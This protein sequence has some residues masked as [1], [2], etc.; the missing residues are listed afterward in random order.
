MI[1]WVDFLLL[2]IFVWGLYR[3]GLRRARRYGAVYKG[4]DQDFA[5][6]CALSIEESPLL[7]L[8]P[9]PEGAEAHSLVFDTESVQY[10]PTSNFRPLFEAVSSPLLV[11]LSWILLDAEGRAI[12]HE[13]HILRTGELISMEA[14]DYHGLTNDYVAGH[15]EPPQEVLREFLSDLSEVHTIVA[16]HLQFHLAMLLHDLPIYGLPTEALRAKSRFCTMRQGLA[17]EAQQYAANVTASYRSLSRLYGELRWGR[18]VEIVYS[19]KSRR[20]VIL[21]THCYNQLRNL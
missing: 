5:P 17:Y 15:G 8:R 13:D 4:S 12:R 6:H 2:F 20:D 7:R 9:A 19:L 10:L 3:V 16:H 11:S 14:T 1:S 18:E 21:A